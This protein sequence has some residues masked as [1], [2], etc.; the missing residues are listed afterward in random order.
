MTA[1]GTRHRLLLVRHTSLAGAEGLC[2]GRHEPGLAASFAEEAAAVRARLPAGPWRLFSSPAAR[3][4][5]LAESL[6]G[7]VAIDAR[8]QEVDFGAWEGRPWA[9]LPAAALAE[10][11]ALMRALKRRD[12]A[13]IMAAEMDRLSERLASEET[14]ALIARLASPNRK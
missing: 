10:S 5:A 12:V 4:R 3:C 8:L 13:E 14:R 9:A 6:G 7:P 11:R 1:P 2:Y